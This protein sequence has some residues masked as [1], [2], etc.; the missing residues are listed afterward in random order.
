MNGNTQAALPATPEPTSPGERAAR[1]ILQ[2]LP[3]AIYTTDAAGRITFYNEAAAEL[4]G[5]RPE[6]GKSEFCGSWKL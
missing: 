1:E 6:L 5:C 2:A 4:W 3:A